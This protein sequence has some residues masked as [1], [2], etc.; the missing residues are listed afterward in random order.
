MNLILRF[1][2]AL[3]HQRHEKLSAD[4]VVINEKPILKSSLEMDKQMAEIYTCNIFYK[5]QDECGMLSRQSIIYAKKMSHMYM[6]ESGT[7]GMVSRLREVVCDKKL[8]TL[9]HVFVT[10]LRV[11]EF[12]AVI[13]WHTCNSLVI[14]LCQIH[15]F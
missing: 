5:F 13:F 2:R 10:S 9:Y 12:H 1:N 8:W 3:A 4:H 11:K 6:V 14:F 15:I 7:N